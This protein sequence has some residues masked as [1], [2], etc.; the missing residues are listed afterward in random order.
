MVVFVSSLVSSVLSVS[1]FSLVLSVVFV[2]SLVSS[3]VFVPLLVSSVLSMTVDQFVISLKRDV[4]CLKAPN[5]VKTRREALTR[6]EGQVKAQI[7]SF[8]V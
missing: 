1:V 4:N 5:D 7:H 2:F 8:L 3:V 6:V